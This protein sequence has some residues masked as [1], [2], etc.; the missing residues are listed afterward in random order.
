[1]GCD[2][3]KATS[4]EVSATQAASV[5][6]SVPTPVKSVAL[7]RYLASSICAVFMFLVSFFVHSVASCDSLLIVSLLVFSR[8]LSRSP[9]GPMVDPHK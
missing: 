7:A 9:L 5:Q 1:M 6:K 2:T 8:A 4:S 3:V